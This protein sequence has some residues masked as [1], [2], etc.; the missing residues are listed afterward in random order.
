[1][2]TERLNQVIINQTTKAHNCIRFTKILQ[3]PLTC[4]GFEP[5]YPIIREYNN[6]AK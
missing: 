5:D 1:M 6:Y 2:A 4:T 3:K